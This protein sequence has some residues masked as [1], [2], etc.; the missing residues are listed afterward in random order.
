MTVNINFDLRQVNGSTIYLPPWEE[1]NDKWGNLA[2]PDVYAIGTAQ[3]YPTGTIYRKGL[4]TFIYSKCAAS[5]YGT[6]GAGIIAGACMEPTA[7]ILIKTD[8]VVSG[9]AGQNVIGVTTSDSVLVD[10][11]AGGTI[12]IMQAAGGLTTVGRGS[13][14]QIISN[15]AESG[16]VT[17]F[18]LDGNLVNVFGT[19][20]DVVLAENPYAECR[21]NV[22]GNY[23]MTTGVNICTTIA[24]GYLWLQTGGM[25]NLLIMMVAFEGAY[26]NGVPCYSVAGTPQIADTSD[27]VVGTATT[28]GIAHGNLQCIGHVYASTDIGGPG[29]TPADVS[30]SPTVFLDIFN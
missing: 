24:S 19:G 28:S 17:Y 22:N 9:A 20:D 25:N 27:G 15:T 12:G 13:T 3:L 29:G 26:P 6:S 8:S 30:I 11:Y 10:A 21:T 23:H 7:E 18:T 1:G 14:Y 4:R 16:N 2:L 5:G